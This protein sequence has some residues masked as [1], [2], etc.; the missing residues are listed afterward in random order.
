MR[1]ELY[2]RD[3]LDDEEFK[4]E[5]QPLKPGFSRPIII[6]RAILGSLERFISILIEHLAGKW[7]FWLSP[8]QIIICP[9]SEK[10]FDYCEK[11]RLYFLQKGYDVEMDKSNTT[12]P[13]K[14]RNAQ[15]DQ[16]N[17]ILVCGEEEMTKGTVTVRSREGQI[18]G[19][20][21]V[22]EAHDFF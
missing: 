17:Y 4:W 9:V 19:S 18:I 22:D 12:L 7:P 10:F 15:V 8:R 16:W 5:E 13:K 20:K 6:H 2:P 21:R 1:H 14:V 3:A 11:V